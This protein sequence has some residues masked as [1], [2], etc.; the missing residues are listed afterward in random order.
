MSILRVDSIRDNG[1]GFNDVVTFAN[2]GGTENGRL[3]RAWVNF[4]GQNTVAI[5]A[6]FNV[7]SITD[8]GTG[9]YTVN[10]TNAMTDVNYAVSGSV[11]GSTYVNT[12][13]W[14]GGP[15]N[16]ANALHSTTSVRFGTPHWSG[17]VYDQDVV[18][19]T[20]HR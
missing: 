15:P 14:I 7:S 19:I 9:D 8:N 11:V 5:N 17:N 4:N 10:F 13:S 16:N 3:C 12:Y 18:Q 2:S 1:S 6:Q 20:I